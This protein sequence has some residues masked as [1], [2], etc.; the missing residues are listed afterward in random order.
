M[1]E[2]KTRHVPYKYRAPGMREGGKKQWKK[3]IAKKKDRKQRERERE[4]ER[5]N[6]NKTQKKKH[7][8]KARGRR[9]GGEKNKSRRPSFPSNERLHQSSLKMLAITV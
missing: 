6:P 8:A 5:K 4:R 3:N 2:E 7:N 9:N 1:R